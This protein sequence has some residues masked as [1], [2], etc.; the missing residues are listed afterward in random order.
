[1]ASLSVPGWPN[2]VEAVKAVKVVKAVKAGSWKERRAQVGGRL[3]TSRRWAALPLPARTTSLTMLPR[4]HVT[5]VAAPHAGQVV[6]EAGVREVG[7][8]AVA[9]D[10]R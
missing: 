2:A 1:M 3:D 9:V 4:R 6:G 8:P 7:V 10:V 5:P